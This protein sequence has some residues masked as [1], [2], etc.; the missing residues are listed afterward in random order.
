MSAEGGDL[1]P[2]GVMWESS[3][4]RSFGTNSV[5]MF[6]LMACS[7]PTRALCWRNVLHKAMTHCWHGGGLEARQDEQGTSRTAVIKGG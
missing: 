2:G 3:S 7:W 5:L 6:V 1:R 4:N